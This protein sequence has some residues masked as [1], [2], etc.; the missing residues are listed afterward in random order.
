[1][2]GFLLCLRDVSHVHILLMV[3]IGLWEN[4]K[5]VFTISFCEVAVK[6]DI[7]Q[8]EKCNKEAWEDVFY[9]TRLQNEL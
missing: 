8:M 3:T 6:I 7:I 4:T 2:K 5:N 9:N 1:M